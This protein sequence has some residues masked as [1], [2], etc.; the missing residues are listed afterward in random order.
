MIHTNKSRVL[1]ELGNGFFQTRHILEV[2]EP[3]PAFRN[4]LIAS[5]SWIQGSADRG[6]AV[7]I[8]REGLG[9]N[10]QCLTGLI[11]KEV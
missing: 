9:I 8:I 11:G 5:D 1:N 10:F 3:M 6:Y 4:P 2:D 7:E